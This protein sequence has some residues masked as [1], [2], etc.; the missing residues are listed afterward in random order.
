VRLIEELRAEHDLIED[1]LFVALQRDA[2]LPGDRG[3][4]AALLDDHHQMGRLLDAM[5]PLAG[6]EG[7]DARGAFRDLALEY[8]KQLLHHIDAENSVLQPESESRL[9]RHAVLEL[10][11]R[12]MTDEERASRA[13]GEAL[14]AAWPPVPEPEILRGDGCVVCPAFTRTCRGLEHEWWNDW[15]WEEFEDH[16][17]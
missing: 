14:V 5:D 15:E 1:T 10:P 7:E 3:P 13:V 2:E 11:T 4:I 17:S 9:R 12:E 16:L 6:D 8:T